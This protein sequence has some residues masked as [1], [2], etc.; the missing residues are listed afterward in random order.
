MR[1]V[2]LNGTY[3]PGY[4][5]FCRRNRGLIDDSYLGEAD[6]AS[7][8]L[9][10]KNPTYVKVSATGRIVGAASV[11]LDDRALG[12]GK[13]RLR[14][15]YSESGKPSSFR[16]FIR[17]L[18]PALAGIDS[19]HVF[20]PDDNNELIGLYE[21]MGFTQERLVLH[22]MQDQT[23]RRKL[24]LPAGHIIRNF[25]R[26][27]DEAAWCYIR[28]SAFADLI[29]NRP[30]SHEEISRIAKDPY[31]SDGGMLVLF[32][33]DAPVGVAGGEKDEYEGKKV[34]HIGPI[35][36]LPEHQGKGLG[37]ALLRAVVNRALDEG[38]GSA[39]LSVNSDNLSAIG[40]YMSEGF[41][42]EKGF[43]CHTLDLRTPKQNFSDCAAA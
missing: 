24:G 26:G 16:C 6:L 4:L 10:P 12:S 5:D 31:N 3:L 37:R 30:V 17:L 39:S 43:A 28:N 32:F 1:F 35:A 36:V 23:E 42:K 13:A 41:K 14:I 2:E 8:T 11:I 40:L 15:F 25:K 18:F 21:G 20:C 34:I 29:G 22:M 9:G 19:L 38:I 7:F 27:Q 33:G